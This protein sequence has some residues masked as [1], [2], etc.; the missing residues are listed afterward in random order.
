MSSSEATALEISL[1]EALAEIAS[2]DKQVVRLNDEIDGLKDRRETLE[3][4]AVRAMADQRLDGVKVAGRSWRIE[5]DH[6]FSVP[7]DRRDLVM[8]AAKAA[9]IP[10]DALVMVNTARLKTIL[11][12]RA[13]DRE[14]DPRMAYSDGTPLEGLVGEYVAPKLRHVTVG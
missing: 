3:R 13:R 12:E 6:H 5:H 2:I 11:K 1:Q 14:A 4:I 8:R 10:E 9:G 7:A